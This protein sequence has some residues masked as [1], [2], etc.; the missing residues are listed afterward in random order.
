MR[1]ADVTRALQIVSDYVRN[2]GVGLAARAG[3]ERRKPERE[4]R[5]RGPGRAGA[6]VG[7]CCEL[8]DAS[9]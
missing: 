2:Y 4:E 3:L 6:D 8:P 1:N 9:S 7:S 5:A